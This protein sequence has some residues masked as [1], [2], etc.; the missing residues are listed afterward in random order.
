[1]NKRNTGPQS[2]IEAVKHYAD[3]DV[4]H[5]YMAKLKWPDGVLVCPVCK[6]ANVGFIKSRRM[7]QCKSQDCRKQFSVKTGTIFEDS[8]LG[9]DK[10][11]VAVW[12]ITNAKN[13]ISSCELARALKVTQKTAWFMLHRVRLAMQTKTF[14]K[15]GGNGA[16]VEIDETYVGGLAEHMHKKQ[17]ALRITSNGVAGKTAIMGLLERH[18]G[19]KHSTVRAQV[20][21]DRRAASLHPVIHKHVVPGATIYTDSLAGYRGL[22]PTFDH[23]FVDHAESYVKDGVIP[24]NGLENFWAILKRAIKGTYIRPTPKHLFRYLDEQIL[25]FNERKGNDADRFATVMPNTLGRRIMYKHLIASGEGDN[26][27]TPM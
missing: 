27:A 2:L 25:R 23:D 7:Y 21:S 4:C 18:S 22:N 15:I 10:W 26:S 13:G 24:T 11:F 3:L 5:V 19:K 20:V 9:L 16:A 1:M 8:P 14:N 6:A 12:C 17:R